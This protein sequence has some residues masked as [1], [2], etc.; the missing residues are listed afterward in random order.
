[1]PSGNLFLSLKKR[2]IAMELH[3]NNEL[4]RMIQ[5]NIEY[6][7]ECVL[8]C[9]NLIDILPTGKVE[10]FAQ[11][12]GECEKCCD[13]AIKASSKTIEELKKHKSNC[14]ISDCVDQ[15]KEAISRLD[16]Q[17][18]DCGEVISQCGQSKPECDDILNN[19]IDSCDG[20]IEILERYHN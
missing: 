4:L 2:G 10:E 1:M 12:F 20:A 14:K 17:I 13:D 16:T 11:R 18:K 3:F 8:A 6:L 7:D 19:C 9:E 5:K 15:C